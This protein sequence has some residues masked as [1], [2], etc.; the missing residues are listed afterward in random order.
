MD[1]GLLPGMDQDA[2]T[3]GADENVSAADMMRSRRVALA[4][5][6]DIL[7]RNRPLDQAIDESGAFSSLPGRDRAFVR[8][9][10]ATTLRRLGQI[11]DFI[12]QA[13][14]RKEPPK[15]PALQNLLRIGAAQIAFMNVPD[16]AVVN[17]SVEIAVKEGLARQKGFV[18]AVLRRMA[19]DHKKW[20]EKQDAGRLNTP[21]WLM[22]TWIADYGL[23]TAAEIAQANLSEAMLD[24]SVKDPSMAEYWAGTLQA[25]ILPTGSLRRSPGGMVFDLPGFDEGGWW[26]Q[27]ASAALP[28]HLF[29]D[30]EGKHIIDMCAAPGGKTMQLATM[31]AD[32]TALDRSAGRM[33]RLKEN[34][35]RLGL[36]DRVRVEIGDAAV[37]TPKEPVDNILLDAPCSATGTVRRHPDLLQLKSERDIERLSGIQERLLH[38]AI[39][40]LKPGGLLVYC[41]CSLQKAESED[42]IEKLLETGAPVERVPVTAAEL[43]GVKALVSETG[44][45]RVFPFHMAAYG[46]MDGFFISRLRKK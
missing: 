16:Y 18:N 34:L 40:I 42:Q 20:I 15:P 35:E 14:D 32:V 43:G 41:T 23:R 1:Q 11:D 26:V 30:V 22:R 27:D 19:A 6:A 8:M 45:V 2:T 17:T 12:R 3:D 46:G 25:S 39:D 13:T 10:V 38:K 37:W 21:E 29:G 5:M 33:K 36:A 44:D 24:I 28:A 7:Q 31:G 9:I 4:L